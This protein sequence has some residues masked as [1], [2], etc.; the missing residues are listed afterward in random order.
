MFDPARDIDTGH[1]AF[2]VR[3]GFIVSSGIVAAATIL[4]ARA[5]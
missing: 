3:I 2:Y 1:R 4:I 5:A